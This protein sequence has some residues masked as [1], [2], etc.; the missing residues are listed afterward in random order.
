MKKEI[1][2]MTVEAHLVPDPDFIP[3]GEYKPTELDE[4]K[5]NADFLITGFF[6]SRT[7]IRFN[8]AVDP[9]DFTEKERCASNPRI[10]YVTDRKLQK[11]KERYSYECDF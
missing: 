5:A 9:N 8:R 1:N 6:G 2:G 3:R 7:E 4:R 11:L 10:F